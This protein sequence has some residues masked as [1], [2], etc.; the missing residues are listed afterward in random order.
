MRRTPLIATCL[1]LAAPV[2][3]EPTHPKDDDGDPKLSLPT[4]ADRLAWQRGGFRLGLGAVYGSFMGSRGAPS[5][6]LLGVALRA[7]VR[8]DEAWSL[9]TSFQYASVARAGGLSGLRFAGTIDPTYHATPNLSLAV[10]FGF[11]GL[12]EGTTGRADPDPK[13]S[14]LDTSYTFPNALTPVA[15]CSGIGVAGLVRGEWAYVLGP[16]TQ[17]S[18]ALEVDAQWTGCVDETGRVEPDTGEAI[19]RRQYWAH[20]GVTLSWGVAWR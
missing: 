7:G 4:E 19:V 14:T 20:T 11:G 2:R 8:L 15:S 12:V 17:T 3:A 6:R 10:G 9:L 18:L 16:R 13:A 5:G 1:A